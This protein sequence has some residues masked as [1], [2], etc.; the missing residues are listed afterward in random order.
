MLAWLYFSAGILLMPAREPWF[1]NERAAHRPL[2]LNL[3]VFSGYSFEQQ[4]RLV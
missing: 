3:T 2:R 4:G 1:H